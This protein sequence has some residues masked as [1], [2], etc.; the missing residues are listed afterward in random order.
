MGIFPNQLI[1][2]KEIRYVSRTAQVDTLK[3]MCATL[4]KKV[5][6]EDEEEVI[7]ANSRNDNTYAALNFIPTAIYHTILQSMYMDGSR[8]V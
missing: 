6:S 8:E 7:S 5:K 2:T 4:G 3:Q 1:I